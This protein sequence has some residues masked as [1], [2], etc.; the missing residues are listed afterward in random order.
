MPSLSKP[1]DTAESGT[2]KDV[3]PIGIYFRTDWRTNQNKKRIRHCDF[4]P[5]PRLGL[6]VARRNV[7]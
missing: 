5:N 6:I 1:G 2:L 7:R 4:L 3:D